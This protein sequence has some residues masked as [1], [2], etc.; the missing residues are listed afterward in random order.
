[1]RMK[2]L[3]IAVAALIATTALA[4]QK[5]DPARLD[6]MIKAAFP[7][8]PADWQSR[9]VGDDTMKECSDTHNSPPNA[10]A[11]AIQKRERAKIKYPA[12]GKLMGDWKNGE[13]LAQSGYGLRFSDYPPRNVNG[14]NCY[15]CHQLTKAEVSYGTVG[16]SLLGY[17]KLRNFAEAD[18]KAAYEKIYDSNA[19]Y[20]CSLMPRFGANSV[21]T[22]DQIKDLVALLM[23]PDSPVNK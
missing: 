7:G 13:K 5:P 6:A 16:S 17:G 4:Q 19:V 9:L 22:I 23:S 20:A 2:I 10:M 14:G 21:L 12:D 3:V 11:E 8:A 1:M 15:A 18:V